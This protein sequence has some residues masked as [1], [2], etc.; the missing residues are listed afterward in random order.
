MGKKEKEKKTGTPAFIKVL[1]ALILIGG[2][3][4]GGV[5]GYSKMIIMTKDRVNEMAGHL[6]Q[7]IRNTH[8]LFADKS[9]K[10]HT[11]D[12]IDKQNDSILKA[13]NII[14]FNQQLVLNQFVNPNASDRRLTR[15]YAD[16]A[17]SN[18]SDVS[19]H[20]KAVMMTKDRVNK[21]QE[22]LSQIIRNTHSLFASQENYNKLKSTAIKNAYMVKA[23]N[24]ISSNRQLVDRFAS[25]GPIGRDQLTDFAGIGRKALNSVTDILQNQPRLDISNLPTQVIRNT[26]YWLTYLNTHICKAPYRFNKENPLSVYCKYKDKKL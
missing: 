16:I 14:S 23:K 11:S 9:N 1:G 3:S 5:T 12:N 2:L 21:M 7:L 24:I 6:S 10:N 19:G 15:N 17:A 26:N 8:V 4:G 22:R 13:K 25:Q 18:S 20:A